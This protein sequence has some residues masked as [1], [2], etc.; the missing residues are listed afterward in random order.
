M[1]VNVMQQAMRSHVSVDDYQYGGP[2]AAIRI[3]LTLIVQLIHCN[4][5][6]YS[7]TCNVVCF[8]KTRS[9]LW[10]LGDNAD[11]IHTH[12]T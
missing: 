11:M 12:I 1:G 6:Y 5:L 4:A 9:M 3:T 7:S 10:L 8:S 2:K